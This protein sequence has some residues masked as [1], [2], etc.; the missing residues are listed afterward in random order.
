MH[1]LNLISVGCLFLLSV[2][3]VTKSLHIVENCGTHMRLKT[4]L[5]MVHAAPTGTASSLDDMVTRALESTGKKEVVIAR[6]D[7]VNWN[8]DV[9]YRP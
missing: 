5:E 3:K 6:I 4:S 7:R 2:T 1:S 9:G 8:T